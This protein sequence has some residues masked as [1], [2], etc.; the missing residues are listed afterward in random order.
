MGARAKLSRDDAM[1]GMVPYTF[2][3]STPRERIA[4]DLAMRLRSAVSNDGYFAQFD[5]I[6]A[7][8]GSH[9]RLGAITVPTLVIHGE[10]DQLVPPENGRELARAIPNASLV[11]LPNASHIFLTDQLEPA[12]D[13]ILAFL[14]RTAAENTTFER[15]ARSA[16]PRFVDPRVKAAPERAARPA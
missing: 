8:P 3:A 12:R 4:Q 9:D 1:W 11:L 15:R 16:F 2:D 7:W 10:T 14:D 5:A 13:A 6:R